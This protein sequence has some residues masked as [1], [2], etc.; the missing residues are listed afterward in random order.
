MRVIA[1]SAKGRRL[2]AV[3][4]QSTRPITDR[5]KEALF[6]ILAETVVDTRFL[7]L[8]AGTGS[9]GIEALSRGACQATFIDNSKRAIATIHRNLQATGLADRATVQKRDAFQ[10]LQ[11][12]GSDAFDIIYVAPPQYKG[13]WSRALQALEGSSLV[14]PETLVVVQIYPKEFETLDLTRFVLRDQRT[15]GSTM[16]C[17]Y[18]VAP[19]TR[20][21]AKGQSHN[22]V[23]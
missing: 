14:A 13:V 19:P 18:A 9:V 1:G 10:L 23:G 4:G 15:Y 7:D 2:S 5:V 22:H 8:F 21:D 6:D 11:D 20:P 17:F 16:L 3:P 12:D